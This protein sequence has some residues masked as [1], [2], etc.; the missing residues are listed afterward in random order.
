MGGLCLQNSFS[1]PAGIDPKTFEFVVSQKLETATS[2]SMNDVM[3]VIQAATGKSQQ[4]SSATI[5]DHYTPMD[6]DAI[7]A[8]RMNAGRYAPPHRR[9]PQQ[10]PQNNRQAGP[11]QNGLPT[12][13]PKP[14]LSIE[15]ATAFRGVPLNSNLT[16]KWGIQCHYCK[17]N[18]HWYN[19]CRLFGEDVSSGVIQPP[20]DG[21]NAPGS[22]YLPP[23]RNFGKHNR[24]RQ[25]DI[26][27]A[28]DGKIL[29]DSGASTH[30]DDLHPDVE[31]NSDD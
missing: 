19:N 11:Q 29:L 15:K 20:P 30:R 9:F 23:D 14:Q 3:T 2:V 7:N 26:P 21:H 24:L 28:S 4:R 25:L 12:S 5:E 6:L 10:H 17:Q 31:G 16:D 27:E 13:Q 8:V 1:A 18:G 22:N